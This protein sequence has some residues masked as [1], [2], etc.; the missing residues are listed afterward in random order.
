MDRDVEM[1]DMRVGTAPWVE[2]TAGRLTGAER[3][4]LLWPLARS[5]VQNTERV[6]GAFRL[7]TT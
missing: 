3:R 6:C 5:H 4:A 1:D 2:R 7:A